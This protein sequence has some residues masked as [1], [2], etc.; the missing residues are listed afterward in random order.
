MINAE[1]PQPIADYFQAAKM[2]EARVVGEKHFDAQFYCEQAAPAG[3][4]QD[5]MSWGA[6]F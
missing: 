1:L 6:A 3:A 2:S 4:P 5:A